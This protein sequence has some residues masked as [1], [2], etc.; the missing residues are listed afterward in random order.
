MATHLVVLKPFL[1]YIRGDIIS[2][3][4]KVV[5]VLESEQKKFV[6]KIVQTLKG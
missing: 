4:K 2:D 5:E 1:N 3:A 6:T